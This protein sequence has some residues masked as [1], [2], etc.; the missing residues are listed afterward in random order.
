MKPSCGDEPVSFILD[1]RHMFFVF[2]T[3]AQMWVLNRSAAV[4]TITIRVQGLELS[5]EKF[6]DL[7]V[8]CGCDY[9]GSI[10]G[11]GPKKA[12]GLVRQVRTRAFVDNPTDS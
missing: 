7:C 11:I 5:H 2:Q 1:V 9:T 8:L 6:V 3:A 4:G 10:K 12:L